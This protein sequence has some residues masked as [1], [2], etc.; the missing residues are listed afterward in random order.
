MSEPLK[1]ALTAVV[2]ITVFV[3]GQIVQKW[4]IEPIQDQRKLVGDI[5]YSIV[6]H[7]NL[8]NYHDHFRSVSRLKQ[9]A[10]KLGADYVALLNEAYDR[11]KTRTD[12]GSEHLR[13]LSAQIHGSI[14]VIP[15]YWLLQTLRIVHSRDALYDVATKLVQWAQNPELETTIQFQND[16]ATLL[17][18]RHLLDRAETRV[19]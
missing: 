4:F 6:L 9:D 17:D 11:L 16:I 18:V 7:S 10:D 1:I 14:Q 19:I 2:G 15:C 3:L 8:F 13:K 12:E 5:V